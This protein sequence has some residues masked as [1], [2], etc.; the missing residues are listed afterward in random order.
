MAALLAM[1]SAR[2][3]F[4]RHQALT[5]LAR[6]SGLRPP[7]QRAFFNIPQNWGVGGAHITKYHIVKPGKDNV[8]YD[9]FMLALPERDHLASF[10]KEVPLFIRYLKLITESEGR[11]GDF[12]AFVQRAQSGLTVES[13]AFITADELGAL[14]WKNGYS[15]EER[16]RLTNIFPKD[17]QFHYPE[18]SV[19]FNIPEEDTYKFCMRTRMEDSHIGELDFSKV[20]RQGWIRD[21]WMIF[22]LGIFIFKY[23]PFFNYYFGV[24]VFGTSMWCY[25]VWTAL[26][27]WIAKTCRR[28]EYM[29]SQ[30]TAQEVMDGEDKIYQAMQRFQNDAKCQ[31]YLADFKGE[32]EAKIAE[33]K[34]GLLLKMQGDLTEK[35]TKQLQAIA[36]FETG[37]SAALQDLVV[38]EAASSFREK[39]PQDSGMQNQALTA[40]VKSLS[41]QTLKPEEDPVALHFTTA[42][43]SLQSGGDPMTA[44]GNPTGTL[45]E[46]VAH[47]MQLKDSEFKQT[48][49]VTAK[50]AE[51]VRSIIKQA[52]AGK[53]FDWSKLTP[54]SA[55]RLDAL[56]SSIN[57]KVGYAVPDFGLQEI[58]KS[59]D[60]AASSY[61]SSVN[62]AILAASQKLRAKQRTCFAQAFE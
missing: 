19:L 49:M 2:Q 56:Y 53:D 23:F 9:D 55:E 33:Y 5:P 18:L 14:M 16:N 4:K 57:Q 3:A 42:L 12:S 11:Q 24:K 52:K 45:A 48:F 15:E 32:T 26:N 10:S 41:G 38:R 51:E 40:A 7:Q 25:T 60:S 22:G 21:H 34:Q 44:K 43:A 35:A 39:F 31:D 13:G 6:G 20:K 47:A 62:S 46:R 61:I 58:G 27:R 59:A 8:E 17:Y 37:M 29:A 28:N 50:E 54:A 30:K 36:N 1:R